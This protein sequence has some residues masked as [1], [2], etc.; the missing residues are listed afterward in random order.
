MYNF[1]KTCTVDKMCATLFVSLVDCQSE[2][3]VAVLVLQGDVRSTPQQGFHTP[4]VAIV[5]RI[6]QP[7]ATRLYNTIMHRSIDGHNPC[8]LQDLTIDY[9]KNFTTILLLTIDEMS[10]FVGKTFHI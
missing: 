4:A 7:R 2:G 5:G 9:S 10:M 8:N 3:R 6:H 1:I